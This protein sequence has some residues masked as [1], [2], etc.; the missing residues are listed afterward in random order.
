M[1]NW[2]FWCDPPVNIPQN[3]TQLAGISKSDVHIVNIF[4]GLG[5]NS[6]DLWKTSWTR[7]DK[8]IHEVFPLSYLC[9][10]IGKVLTHLFWLQHW[11]RMLKCHFQAICICSKSLIQVLIILILKTDVWWCC[12]SNYLLYNS[13]YLY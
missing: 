1:K 5:N 13:V 6:S 12:T 10:T 2:T 7:R 4:W 3:I 8:L 11:A 9:P